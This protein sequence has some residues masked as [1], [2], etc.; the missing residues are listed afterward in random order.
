LSGIPGSMAR[1]GPDHCPRSRSAVQHTA[2]ATVAGTSRRSPRSCCLQP[3]WPPPR[4][5]PGR[6]PST[7]WPSHHTW[8]CRHPPGLV[9]P[10]IPIWPAVRPKCGPNQ[11]PAAEALEALRLVG[12]DQIFDSGQVAGPF[13]EVGRVVSRPCLVGLEHTQATCCRRD[14]SRCSFAKTL[15]ICGR[16]R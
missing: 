14:R 16:I 6:K 5:S 15:D 10:A 8:G 13:T 4:R 1:D 7:R 2:S 12:D 11:I 9:H 3:T